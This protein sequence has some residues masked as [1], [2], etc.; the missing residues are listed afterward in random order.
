MLKPVSIACAASDTIIEHININIKKTT[1]KQR[2]TPG[3]SASASRRC[4]GREATAG[5]SN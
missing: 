3:N 1:S 5:L 2:E 4:S